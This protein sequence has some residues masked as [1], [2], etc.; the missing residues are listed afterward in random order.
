MLPFYLYLVAVTF[1]FPPFATQL[2]WETWALA[3][4]AKIFTF[5][6]PA[7]GLPIDVVF[8]K[9]ENPGAADTRFD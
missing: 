3:G 7:T 8:G 6:N 2:E 9:K 5:I 1:P 4:I